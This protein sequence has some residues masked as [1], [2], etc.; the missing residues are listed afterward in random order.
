MHGIGLVD[1]HPIVREGLAWLIERESD[2]KVVGQAGS[3][4]EARA[5][6]TQHEDMKCLLL[7]LTLQRTEAFPLLQEL[8]LLRPTLPIVVLSMHDELLFAPRAVRAG[9]SG[10]VMKEAATH[11][12]IAAIRVVLAGGLWVSPR[13]REQLSQPE[14]TLP[15]DTL[16]E[17]PLH[18]LTAREREVFS[19]LGRGLGTKAIAAELG[20]SAKTIETYRA[21]IK[22]KLGI[23]SLSELIVR[24][25]RWV[26]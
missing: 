10:Y 25:A 16:R 3:A 15:P 13:V 21:H 26:G 24:A 14:H 2:L 7:D 6:V 22:E 11:A 12:L 4:E 23:D 9:A 17:L 5:L 18:A 19:L 8:K 1:D 20:I